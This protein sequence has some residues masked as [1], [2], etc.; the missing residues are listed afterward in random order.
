MSELSFAPVSDAALVLWTAC[1][2]E[3]G[4]AEVRHLLSLL[5]GEGV[6]LYAKEEGK[7]VSQGL[8]L[9]FTIG[10]RRGYYLYALCTHPAHRGQGYMRTLLL[11]AR[12]R[13]TAE[14]MDHLILIPATKELG[15]TYHRQGFTVE[16]PLAAD[17]AGAHPVYRLPNG[18]SVT[19]FDG[20]WEE[21]F[22]RYHGGLSPSLFRAALTSVADKTKIFYTEDGFCVLAASSPRECFTADEKTLSQCT[23]CPSPYR[24]L[25]CPLTDVSL[26]V[27]DADPLPR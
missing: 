26:T 2:P 27:G 10:G 16:V 12:E 23:K 3:D 15:D 18:L 9:P 19:P 17:A 14:G 5:A 1:F 6:M 13:A 20:N 11:A 24:A 25:L 8:L 22:S 7:T 4:E 21:L